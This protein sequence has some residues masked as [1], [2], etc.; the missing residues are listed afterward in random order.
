MRAVADGI[1]VGTEPECLAAGHAHEV[2]THLEETFQVSHREDEVPA[3]ADRADIDRG[4]GHVG[5]IH[6]EVVIPQTHAR[7]ADPAGTHHPGIP[8]RERE[9]LDVRVAASAAR[10]ERPE[11]D[12]V[13]LLPRPVSP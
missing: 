7:L 13:A 11:I 6:A 4:A 5:R 3:E 2:L 10:G 9:I 1:D 12:V 8:E